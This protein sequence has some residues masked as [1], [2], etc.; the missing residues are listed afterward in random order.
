MGRDERTRDP[1]ARA[2]VGRYTQRTEVRLAFTSVHK[3][4]FDD[5]DGAGIVYYPQ[6]LKLCHACFEDYFDTAASV[7][8]PELI[9][10]RRRGFPT[11][12]I[13]ADFKAPLAYGDTAVVDVVVLRLGRSSVEFEYTIVRRRDGAVA[14]RAR[15]TCAY[16]DLDAQKAVPL[17]DEVRALLARL[18]AVPPA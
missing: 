16:M 14:F 4:R 15:I 1:R 8:Y 3:I 7:S 11:V 10:R 6:F 5:V 12:H 2:R 9:H 17:D 13:E 18:E